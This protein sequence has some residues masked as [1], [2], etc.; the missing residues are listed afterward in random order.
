MQGQSSYTRFKEER[1]APIFAQ[2]LRISKTD[3]VKRFA[4]Y[5]IDLNAG[6]GYNDDV[7][8]AGSPV[9]FLGEAAR[10]DRHNFFAFFV[11]QDLTA[12]KQLIRRPEV[13]A[14]PEQIAIYPYD[15]SEILS[16]VSRFIA[17]REPNPQKAIGSIVVD[18]N[19]YRLGVPWDALKTFCEAHPRFDLIMNLNVRTLQ[20]ERGCVECGM[21]GF[22]TVE[23]VL[24]SEFPDWF[25]RP[26]WMITEVCSI[27]RWRWVQLVGR[28]METRGADYPSIGFYDMRSERGR[29]II[30]GIEGR[31]ETSRGPLELPLLSDL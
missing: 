10:C 25:T 20:L 16:V 8:V 4:F 5:H 28:T 3:R 1:F 23:H 11:D 13:E 22:E 19:G 14:Y 27:G 15:N 24:I 18:P 17:R 6:S 9:N 7:R 29:A 26:N 31:D 30:A 21:K 12:I 2:S